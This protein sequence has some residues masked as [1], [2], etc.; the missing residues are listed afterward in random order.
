[1]TDPL[2]ASSKIFIDLDDESQAYV[3]I[4]LLALKFIKSNPCKVC[5]RLGFDRSEIGMS[6]FIYVHRGRTEA[7]EK[8]SFLNP[9]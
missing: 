5:R 6:S 8:D 9:G 3:K 4:I 7:S 2:P 1:M